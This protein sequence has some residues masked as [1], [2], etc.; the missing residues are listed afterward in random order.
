VNNTLISGSSRGIGFNIAAYLREQGIRVVTNSRSKIE[1][2][3]SLNSHLV[4][5]CSDRSQVAHALEK[6]SVHDKSLKNL[7]MCVGSGSIRNKDSDLRWNTNIHQNLLSGIVL[8]EE[9]IKQFDSLKNV[10]F[11]SSI[12]GE[13]IMKDPPVE[14]SVAKSALNHYVKHMAAKHAA[15][16]LLINAVS[17]GNVFFKDSTWDKR[18]IS[19]PMGTQ[20]YITS[21]VP[22]GKF[23]SMESISSL[24][25][26]LI[27]KNEDITGQIIAVDGGQSLR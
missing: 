21:S 25:H 23:V 4:F 15:S 8:F 14:Y 5:D 13:L 11:I 27:S 19:D 18:M 6:L 16:G 24:V 3:D 7:I 9:A 10:I 2:P 17:P 12:A 26:F 1:V 22:S 20:E